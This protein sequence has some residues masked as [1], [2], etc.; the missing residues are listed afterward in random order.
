M[1]VDRVTTFETD[2]GTYCLAEADLSML[3]Y[4]TQENRRCSLDYFFFKGSL[5]ELP[6]L[7]QRCEI[8]VYRGISVCEEAEGSKERKDFCCYCYC[9]CS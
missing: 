5:T 2:F 4:C 8:G 6:P 1:S 7:M 3:N 9:C